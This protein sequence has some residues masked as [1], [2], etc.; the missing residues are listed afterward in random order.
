MSSSIDEIS[1]LDQ[2]SIVES[3]SSKKDE[4]NSGRK[5]TVKSDSS[6]KDKVNSVL[7]STVNKDKID[8]IVIRSS[9]AITTEVPIET[10]LEKDENQ[11][12]TLFKLNNAN[13]RIHLF[14]YN[15]DEIDSLRETLR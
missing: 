4:M 6:K 2:K 14:D 10:Y 7:K 9:D 5:S 15:I 13:E 3:N 11:V 1:F 8:Q 12:S